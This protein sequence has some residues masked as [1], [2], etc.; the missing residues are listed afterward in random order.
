MSRSESLTTSGHSSRSSR[1]SWK[2]SSRSNSWTTSGCIGARA[3]GAESR[4]GTQRSISRSPTVSSRG[5]ASLARRTKA[6][7]GSNHTMATRPRSSSSSIGSRRTRP[8]AS[9]TFLELTTCARPLAEDESLDPKVWQSLHI[10]NAFEKAASFDLIHNH[11]DF[12]PLSYGGLVSTP[13]VTT[14]HGFSS[15][16]IR[17]AY[18]RYDGRTSYVSISDAD[19]DPDLH[20]VATVYHGIDL[21]EFTL[22]EKPGPGLV[23]L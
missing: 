6:S 12:L 19:R 15:N 9:A 8:S 16:R 2:A 13:L 23:F 17:P 14:I 20:Y 3:S 21:A 4:N 5:G 22:I 7:S 1:A 10:A 18:R 11:Y